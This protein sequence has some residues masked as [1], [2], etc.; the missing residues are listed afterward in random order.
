MAGVVYDPYSTEIHQDPYP[1]LSRLRTEAPVYH[2][3][4]RGFWAVSRYED[5]AAVSLDWERFTTRFGVD[6]DNYGD[7]LGGG[8]FLAQDPP[9][10]TKLR[11][12]CRTAFGPARLREQT[13]AAIR[14]EV[15][16]L[17][18]RLARGQATDLA[19]DLA[20][21][22][23]A[24]AMSVF[25][26]F[27]REDC[28]RLRQ[29]GIDFLTRN[30]GDPQPPPA[31]DEAGMALMDYF[32]NI[33]WQRA[34]Q[35][36][37]DLLSTIST[38][39]IDGQPIGDSAE[40]LALLLF[41]GGFENVG[42]SITN[43]LYWLARHPDQRSWLAANPSQIPA[44]IEEALRFDAPQQ[45]FKRTT[46]RDVELRGIQIPA[47][48]PVIL[49]YGAANRDEQRWDQPDIFDIRREPKHHMAFGHGIHHCIGAPLARLEAQIVL[50]VVLAEIPH[51]EF[52]ADPR[53]LPS[54]AVRG[55]AKLP[56]VASPAAA[57][58]AL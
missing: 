29:L 52:T 9:Q 41:V 18:G 5:V 31:S 40:G 56:V 4:E 25:L 49:L 32:H 19:A 28:D 27:P 47:G 20:W 3:P 26:G 8:F 13:E 50:E 21:E 33:C 43:T 46:T 17:V 16:A 48:Q 11:A 24:R 12:V 51:Y 14:S 23:P 58:T 42:C 7:V 35:P 1:V 22:L 38:A 53:R 54:H 10:H 37:G 6:I 36:T 45:N 30:V 55:F 15:Q 44:A 57:V 34:S 2:N 39:S